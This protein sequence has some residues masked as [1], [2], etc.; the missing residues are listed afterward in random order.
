MKCI[1]VIHKKIGLPILILFFV[2]TLTG[3]HKTIFI[4]YKPINKISV[5]EIAATHT[6]PSQFYLCG[7]SQY[8]CTSNARLNKTIKHEQISFKQHQGNYYEKYTAR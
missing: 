7:N 2:I 1:N 3:C 5:K 8:P 4:C 6:Y